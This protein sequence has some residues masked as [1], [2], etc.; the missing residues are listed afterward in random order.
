M[1]LWRMSSW[2]ITETAAATL[3]VRCRSWE[4]EVISMFMR[5][6]IDTSARSTRALCAWPGLDDSRR[7]TTIAAMRPDVRR[8]TIAG[9]CG[10]R[11]QVMFVGS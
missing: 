9:A 11:G 10:D 5:S 1:P 3:T 6:S 2:V 8:F 4:A 7:I